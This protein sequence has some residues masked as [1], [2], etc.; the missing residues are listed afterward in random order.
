MVETLLWC[1]GFAV[2]VI[3]SIVM[4]ACVVLVAPKPSLTELATSERDR[5]SERQMRVDPA[6]RCP[7]LL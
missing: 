2:P 7:E 4:V 5:D 1:V 6:S 3:A